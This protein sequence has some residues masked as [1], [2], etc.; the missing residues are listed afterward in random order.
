[1]THVTQVLATPIHPTRPRKPQ[2]EKAGVLFDRRYVPWINVFSTNNGSNMPHG[3][4]VEY[5]G[6][7]MTW[8]EKGGF[9]KYSK[10][11][12]APTNEEIGRF[13]RDVYE[14]AK[15]QDGVKTF[16]ANVTSFPKPEDL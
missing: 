9:T 16:L 5:D 6:Y 8:D 13:I 1:M 14:T 2:L 4:G 15:A 10:E 12:N 11:G 7:R 3:I